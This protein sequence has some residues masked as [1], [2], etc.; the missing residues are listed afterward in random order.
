MRGSNHERKANNP[1]FYNVFLSD[2]SI[3][4]SIMGGMGIAIFERIPAVCY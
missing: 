2:V 1:Y 3:N 4:D